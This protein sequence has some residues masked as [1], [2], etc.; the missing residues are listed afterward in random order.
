MD[1]QT[2]LRG[3]VEN[4]GA[5]MIGYGVGPD[6]WEFVIGP[7]ETARTLNPGQKA[8]STTEVPAQDDRRD[9]QAGISPTGG[10]QV[11]AT[12]RYAGFLIA[13]GA[14]V[15]RGICLPQGHEFST[16]FKLAIQDALTGRVRQ[17]LAG[18]H[19]NPQE[20]VGLTVSGTEAAVHEGSKLPR[21]SGQ[22]IFCWTHRGI[23]GH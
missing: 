6:G 14:Q 15:F 9:A 7:D 12:Q 17:Y 11:A 4:T 1:A 3:V 5:Q 2:E 21:L 22:E 10:E 18:M 16:Q 13:V 20:F 23:T 8:A 19:T